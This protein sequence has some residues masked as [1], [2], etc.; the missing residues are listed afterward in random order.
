[1]KT[2]LSFRFPAV[3]VL[4]VDVFSRF[5][6]FRSGAVASAKTRYAGGQSKKE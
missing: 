2:V 6:H 3:L 5:Q 1:M 4:A